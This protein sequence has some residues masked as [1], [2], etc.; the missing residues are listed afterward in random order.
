MIK[1]NWCSFLVD[2]FFIL[3]FLSGNEQILELLTW[4]KETADFQFGKR[5]LVGDQGGWNVCC[6][7]ATGLQPFG[8]LSIPGNAGAAFSVLILKSLLKE[9]VK[10]VSVLENVECF[11]VSYSIQLEAWK[12]ISE[13]WQALEAGCV[14]DGCFP[15]CLKC[16][17]CSVW[18]IKKS[19]ECWSAWEKV[20]REHLRKSHSWSRSMILS[21]RSAE[22][23]HGLD[24]LKYFPGDPFSS[25]TDC[26][27]F[28]FCFWF[29]MFPQKAPESTPKMPSHRQT[30]GAWGV[31]SVTEKSTCWTGRGLP[32]LL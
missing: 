32:A 27:H 18:C 15:R 6:F 22:G 17:N 8:N 13:H 16:Q 10:T 26:K 3:H 19:G 5:L 4:N 23:F 11:S 9:W 25:H 29:G 28:L 20:W 21:G 1:T 7:R 24:E 2:K 30:Q 12:G 14:L 31:L